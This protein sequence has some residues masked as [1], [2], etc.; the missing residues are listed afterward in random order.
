MKK[1]PALGQSNGRNAKAAYEYKPLIDFVM[2]QDGF[3][4]DFEYGSESPYRYNQGGRKPAKFYAEVTFAEVTSRFEFE[5]G[6]LLKQTKGTQFVLQ[7]KSRWITLSF[8]TIAAYENLK[9]AE[10]KLSE[11]EAR[12]S[13]VTAIKL[14]ALE[15]ANPLQQLPKGRIPVSVKPWQNAREAYYPIIEFAIAHGCKIN[16]ITDGPDNYF[17]HD[18][19][20]SFVCLMEGPLTARNLLEEFK[21]NPDVLIPFDIDYPGFALHDVEHSIIIICG[22]T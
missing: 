1:T 19:G 6:V 17:E 21:F 14:K 4:V 10:R 5:D 3:A 22:P 9:K 18:S 20:G 15:G 8:D 12:D 2:K 13:A 11:L 16:P 7:D